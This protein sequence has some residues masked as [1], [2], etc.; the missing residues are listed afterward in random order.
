MENNPTKEAEHSPLIHELD[1]ILV[2][3]NRMTQ[4]NF[5]AIQLLET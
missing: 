1:A 3:I 4:K 2:R 5:G